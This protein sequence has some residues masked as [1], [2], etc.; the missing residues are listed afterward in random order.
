MTDTT[1]AYS[2][3]AQ[4]SI[5]VLTHAQLDDL[6]EE[7]RERGMDAE[8]LADFETWHRSVLDKWYTSK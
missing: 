3:T 6:I 4:S 1:K 5:T 2:F 8:T 7:R